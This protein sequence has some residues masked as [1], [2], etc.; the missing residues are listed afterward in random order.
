LTRPIPARPSQ[1]TINP[2]LA[3]EKILVGQLQQD[4]AAANRAR[5]RGIWIHRALELLATDSGGKQAG[6][7][8]RLE[9]ERELGNDLIERYWQ[10]AAGIVKNERFAKYFGR[11]AFTYD[12]NEMPLLYFTGNDT[13]YGVVDRII[14]TGESV[15]VLDYKTH[16]SA[17]LENINELA[18]P[19]YR[20]MQFY[21]DGVAALWPQK[22]VSLILLFTACGEIVEVPYP[23]E[24]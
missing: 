1:A 2:S 8:F 13:V 3:D 10:E 20:Q 15:T 18:Q 6:Q 24:T 17:T 21:G 23:A 4:P 9:A 19:Y 22:K 5:E 14:L 12:F 11:S 16:E 7:Q